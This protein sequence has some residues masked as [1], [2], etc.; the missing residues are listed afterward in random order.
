MSF[1]CDSGRVCHAAGDVEGARAALT[2]ARG[3]AALNDFSDQESQEDLAGL[4]AL[5]D[6]G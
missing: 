4:A 3:I 2:R 6:R 5:L 1:L